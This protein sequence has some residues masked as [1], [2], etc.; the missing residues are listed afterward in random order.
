MYPVRLEVKFVLPGW[1]SA[2]QDV[3]GVDPPP[4]EIYECKSD[5]YDLVVG[6]FRGMTEVRD[7]CDWHGI[8]VVLA[9]STLQKAQYLIDAIDDLGLA[10]PDGFVQCTQENILSLKDTSPALPL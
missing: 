5:P 9:I 7:Q 6:V 3:V 8:D 4:I 10:V 1:L 2:R